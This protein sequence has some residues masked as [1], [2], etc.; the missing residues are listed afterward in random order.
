MQSSSSSRLPFSP[1][2]ELASYYQDSGS[3]KT[4]TMAQ[5]MHTFAV[6]IHHE[7]K[8]I[9]NINGD[10]ELDKLDK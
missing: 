7:T 10:I 9:Y 5:T 2:K 1:F 6:C 3:G 8:H 4:W